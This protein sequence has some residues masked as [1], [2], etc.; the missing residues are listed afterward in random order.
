MV[1]GAAILIGRAGFA[2]PFRWVDRK[3]R[4]NPSIDWFLAVLYGRAG[5]TNRALPEGSVIGGWDSGILGYFSRFPVVNMDGLVNSYDYLDSIIRQRP[6]AIAEYANLA[7]VLKRWRSTRRYGITHFA[8]T[9]SNQRLRPNPESTWYIKALRHDTP[10]Y[11]VNQF[12]VWTYDLHAW[13]V[14]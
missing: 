11:G 8:N 12:G 1:I 5:H 14:C 4:F 2:E 13:R 10:G 7:E 9:V 6:L 3:E